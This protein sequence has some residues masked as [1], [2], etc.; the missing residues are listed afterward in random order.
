V[1]GE[2]EDDVAKVQE[3]ASY[4]FEDSIF[5]SE[6]INKNYEITNH[7]REKFIRFQ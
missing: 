7:A 3:V 2:A 5:L 4:P 1:P 6:K